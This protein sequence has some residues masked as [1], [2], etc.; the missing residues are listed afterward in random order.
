M[1]DL[2]SESDEPLREFRG[3]HRS[4]IGCV[5]FSPDGRLLAT[6]GDDRTIQV[7]DAVA[8]TWKY[9]LSGH[10]AAITS[11]QFLPEGRLLSA[12]RDTTL[13]LWQVGN[14]SGKELRSVADHRSGDVA[15]LSAS[16]D[17]Q[18]VLIDQGRELRLVS[19]P[20]RTIEGSLHNPGSAGGSFTTMALFSPDGRLALT[21]A[22]SE[23]RLQL[24]RLPTEETRAYELRQL[25][26]PD[27]SLA[28]CGAFAPDGSFI[29]TG[30]R[31]RQVY[32]WAMPSKNEI[33]HLLTATVTYIEPSVE[34][35]G[36]QVRIWAELPNKDGR[37]IPGMSATMVAY[38]R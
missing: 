16:P 33:E 4:A 22:S 14:E 37:L 36:R 19:V 27:R 5:A 29:V 3:Y 24:W 9:T 25:A 31:D 28:T 32:V 11:L 8:G 23:G 17:G 6:G 7:W 15:F 18:R 30:S 2:G 10:R 13:R 12:A 1:Y 35:A 21:A 26:T 38:P 34:S 20:R